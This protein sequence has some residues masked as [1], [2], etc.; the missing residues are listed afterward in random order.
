[1]KKISSETLCRR[2]FIEWLGKATMLSLS[3]PLLLSA[4]S[5][6]Q[7][8]PEDAIA[9]EE[10]GGRDSQGADGG[11]QGGAGA[12]GGSLCDGGEGDFSF[13]PGEG[14]PDLFDRWP[15]RT[16]DPQNLA[17]ILSSWRLTVD[18]MVDR[19]W[20]YDFGELLCLPRHQQ[21]TDF[22]CVEGWSVHDIPWKG[23]HL[24]EIVAK[25]RPQARATHLTF[26][27]QGGIYTDSLPLPIALEPKTMLAYGVG[28]AT[29]P[30]THGFPL[31]LI[32]PRLLAYKNSKYVD[33]IEFTDHP[34]NG[35]WVSKGYP[36][37]GLV[38][39]GR[40]REGMY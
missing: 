25:V 29:L 23:L 3:S 31:R 33:R 15:V 10:D 20:T 32:I 8:L 1:M 14:R 22:H 26:H 13:Q 12:D 6:N 18:G 19:P 35:F 36:Y 21:I 38:P 24:S 2:S 30:L 39:Q 4:L 34:I 16:V 37:D 9:P 28:G 7:L 17:H 27:S 11:G 5:C 40:L